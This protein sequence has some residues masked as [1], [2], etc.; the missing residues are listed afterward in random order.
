MRPIAAWRALL[1]VSHETDRARFI[2]R[3][4]SLADPL[5]MHGR[6]AVEHRRRG[7]RSGGG[8]PL[9]G[10]DATPNGYA[11]RRPGHRRRGV[12][13]TSCLALIEKYRD[14]RLADRVF[15]L[16][17]THAQMLLRQLDVGAELAQTFARIAG[18]LL[19]AQPTAARRSEH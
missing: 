15:E 7:A 4:R 10:H 14:R 9:R 12:A 16:A 1:E 2:G 11:H 17:W 3:R 5:A 8:Q 19:Y 18:A 6:A 13:A